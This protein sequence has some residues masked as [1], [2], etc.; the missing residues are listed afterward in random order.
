MQ[1]AAIP[2]PSQWHSRS[3]PPTQPMQDDSLCC[4]PGPSHNQTS[5]DNMDFFTHGNQYPNP[6]ESIDPHAALRQK[7]QAFV[8]AANQQ[9]LELCGLAT[10]EVDVIVRM[11]SEARLCLYLSP[12]RHFVLGSDAQ[13]HGS[14]DAVVSR[15]A[16]PRGRSRRDKKGGLS[17]LRRLVSNS[18][19]ERVGG[20]CW[21]CKLTKKGAS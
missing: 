10:D 7:V 2:D 15:H 21:H 19:L 16:F 14:L 20:S 11:V 5:H 18:E 8:D 12:C 4:L 6:T 1:A 3:N 13:F 9:Q 17:V